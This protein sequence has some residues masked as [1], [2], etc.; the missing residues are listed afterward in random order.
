M[1]VL[2]LTPGQAVYHDFIVA[3]ATCTPAKRLFA[4]YVVDAHLDT[5]RLSAAVDRIV[6]L[7]DSL[8]TAIEP[9]H[10]GPAQVIREPA[11]ITEPATRIV[12]WDGSPHGAAEHIEAMDDWWAVPR[13]LALQMVAGT[14]PGERTFLACVLN[15]TCS[16]GISAEM[17]FDQIRA[18][19]DGTTV[20]PD[21]VEQFSDYYARVLDEGLGETLEDWT[22]LL[23]QGYPVLPD[24]MVEE[25]LTTSEVSIGI[26]RW[27]FAAA[28]VQAVASVAQQRACTQFEVLAACAGLYFRREDG[29][30]GSFGIIHSGRHGFR[31]FDVHGLLRSYAVD[32]VDH[33][34]IPTIGDA[35]ERRRDQLRSRLEHFAR[36]P[37]E[38]ACDRTGR[39]P[40]WRAGQLGAWEVELNG[41]YP[42]A[43][44]M[45]M[46][47]ARVHVAD[48]PVPEEARCENGGPTL[49]FSFTLDS[50]DVGASLRF[51]SPPIDA[52]LA[53][54]IAG[55][56]EATAR[57]ACDHPDAPVSD[58]PAFFRRT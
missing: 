46:Q 49:L 58:A 47:Q 1:R 8:R 21:S 42:A 50:Q 19:Y 14:G 36:L 24:R 25:K 48:V 39:S 4:A 40:G 38:E 37:F 9:V 11:E 43:R 56:L 29:R 41:M 23:D 27:A 2:P 26:H 7:H 18:E 31:G 28:S 33:A 16:D 10:D 53:A 22:R 5:G 52:S 51:V 32:V 20:K 17:V 12:T 55:D 35:V 57:F 6:A 30:P 44:D 45:T 15:H 3:P 54:L 13:P 34:G